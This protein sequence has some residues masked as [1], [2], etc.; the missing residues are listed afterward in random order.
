MP[1]LPEV[2]TVKETLKRQVLGKIIKEAKIYYPNVIASPSVEEFKKQI[3]GQKI[4][5]ILRRGKWL[6]FELDNYYLLSHLRMEG[7]YFIRKEGQEIGKHEHI[8]LIF[9]DNTELRYHDTRKF[10]RMYLLSKKN[11]YEVKPL[12]ELGLEPWDQNLT[13]NYLKNKLSSKK[14]AIKT[15][16]LDQSIMVGNGNIYVDEVLFL[17]QI[18]PC[19]PANEIDDEYLQRIIDNTRMTLEKAIK[20]GGTTIRTYTSSEGVHGLFQHELL[21]HG[22]DHGLCPVCKSP[23]L[24]IRVNGRGTYYCPKCQK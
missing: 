13:V 19:T 10:G 2:E 24:K 3:I 11:I 6:M 18:N 5:N 1:E 14:I 20:K 4:N 17:S 22:K 23:I 15:A 7:K 21:V 9:S 8:S 16:I 12:S